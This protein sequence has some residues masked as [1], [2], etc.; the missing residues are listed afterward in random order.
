MIRFALTIFTSA[1]LL[2]QVQPLIARYILPWFGGTPAVWST[3]MLFFQLVLLGGYAYAH[4]L[5]RFFNPRK[6]AAIHLALLVAACFMLPIIPRDSLRPTGG[7]DP[8]SQ[9]LLVL[10]LTIGLPYFAVSTTGPLMQSWFAESYPGRSPYR[11]FALSNFGSLVALLTYPFVFEP[12]LR[13]TTQALGWSIGFVGFAV[14]CGWC[15][16]LVYR[17]PGSGHRQPESEPAQKLSEEAT[18]RSNYRIRPGVLL[19]LLWV[20][21]SMVPSILL[22]ATTNQVCQEIAVVPF[23]WVVPL[24]LYLVTFIICFEAPYLY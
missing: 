1:F 22:L 4:A 8:V 17:Q 18:A 12:Y 15:G 9:I 2:F 16:L 20:G 3:C 5:N 19:I 14:L 24:A 21:L 7:E 11:L 23:L 10:S 13:Q 6:Q